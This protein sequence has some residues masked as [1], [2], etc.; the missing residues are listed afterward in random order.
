MAQ[1]SDEA[2]APCRVQVRFRKCLPQ[3]NC[4]G[5]GGQHCEQSHEQR[6]RGL[7]GR[8]RRVP[9]VRCTTLH[10]H[11][12][13]RLLALPFSSLASYC[14]LTPRCLWDTSAHCADGFSTSRSGGTVEACK[15]C[16]SG[17]EI[18]QA[19]AWVLIIVVG[20][21]GTFTIGMWLAQR[22]STDMNGNFKQLRSMQADAKIIFGDTNCLPGAYV[23]WAC[24]S[25]APGL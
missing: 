3:C 22:P 19:V 23:A 10:A 5:G 15:S 24:S 25:L 6:F 13:V 9:L 14:C 17:A 7:L 4:R 8:V 12:H 1:P 20:I 18:M 21:L 16:D 11:N 2:L